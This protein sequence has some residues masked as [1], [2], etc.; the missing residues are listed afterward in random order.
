LK[1]QRNNGENMYDI[2]KLLLNL[3]KNDYSEHLS[4]ESFIVDC[5]LGQN[6]YGFNPDVNV[7]LDIFKTLDSYPH[8]DSELKKAIIKRFSKRV[9]LNEDNISLTCGSIE[10][11]FSLNRVFM[12][13]GK[14]VIGTAPQFT[15][16]IDDIH[17]YE[18][19]YIPVFLNKEKNFKFNTDDFLKTIYENH[20]SYIYIDNPNNPTGQVIPISE[21]EKIIAA[22]QKNNSFVCIDEAY[23]DYME[24]DNSAINLIGKYDNFA[25]VRSLSKALGAAGIRIGYIISGANF[26]KIFNKVKLP[27]A[28]TSL[29]IY[30][31]Q[32]IVNSGWEEFAKKQ[33]RKNKPVIRENLSTIRTSY[34]DDS[35][36]ICLY[37]V[38]NKDINL[39][40]VLIKHG[41]RVVTCEG[42]DGLGKNYVRI[43]L[44]KDFNTMLECLKKADKEL[45]GI[46]S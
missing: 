11:L 40:K 14:K 41:I 17:I 31:G 23:G 2:N 26:I 25:L 19:V 27:F 8:S 38:E 36:P 6:P 24:D 7:D 39:E 9:E 44:N 42:Y 22:A 13:K 5:S 35:V 16:V 33:S 12:Y 30:I 10:A 37:Y 45:S 1:T 32:Q 18:A 29:S 15:A 20:S 43:N 46:T 4:D 34:T 3:V 28:A 21:I